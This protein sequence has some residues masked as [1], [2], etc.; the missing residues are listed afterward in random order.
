MR[1]RIIANG[2]DPNAFTVLDQL[3][4][5]GRRGMGALIYEP[6]I[7]HETDPER[8]DLDALAREAFELL[9]GREATAEVMSILEELGGSSGGARPKIFVARDERGA[10]RG[11]SG[12][13]LTP[14]FTAWLLKFRSPADHREVGPLEAAYADMAR[15]AG[16]DVAPTALVP[17]PSG[18]PGFFAT[19]RFDRRPDGERIHVLSV[20]GLLDI[21]WETPRIDYHGLLSA[22]RFVTR[23]EADV[24]RMFRRMVFNVAA[25]NL[26][27]HTKQHAF[28]MDAWGSW[29]LAP[30]YDVN[31][32]N[33]PNGQHYLAVEGEASAIARD[34]VLAVARRQG[35]SMP[36]AA[37]IVDDVR[38][39]VSSFTSYAKPYDV[40]R[41]AVNE[42]AS[43]LA[44]L[45][46]ALGEPALRA[47]TAPKAARTIRRR[48]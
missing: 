22:T 46:A 30:A 28:L 37:A 4:M 8:I 7:P 15:G 21:E 20:S 26:D 33:G 19:E 14:G 3:A 40:S 18:G 29:R 23:N 39:A 25:H 34:H 41:T 27:D 13:R 17:S 2:L 12:E 47:R 32:S 45:I 16:I 43:S 6:A 10:L 48:K 1:R 38:H 24:V 9:E 31:F 44:P 42:I 35:I 11:G 5:V 36:T